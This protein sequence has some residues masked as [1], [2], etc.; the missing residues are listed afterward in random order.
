MKHGLVAQGEG[1][2]EGGAKP[3]ETESRDGGGTKS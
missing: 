1:R 3:E 2:F